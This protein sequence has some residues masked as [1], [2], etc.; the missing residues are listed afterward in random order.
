MEGIKFSEDE[1]AKIVGS[2]DFSKLQG[3]LPALAVDENGRVLMLA[4]M[5]REAV[6]RTLK[7][8]MMHYWSR[9]RKRLWMKGEESGHHQYVLGAY[10]DCDDDSLLFRVHQVGPACHT[11][12]KTCFFKILREFSGGPEVLG[13]LEEVIRDRMQNPVEGSHTS[14][15]IRKGIKQAAKK[16]GEEA[17]EVAVAALAEDTERTVYEAADLLYH[18]E[19]LL[20][21]K[22]TGIGEVY[23][24]LARRRKGAV[25]EGKQKN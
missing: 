14:D 5:N 7:T 12:E 8:G 13:D 16:V 9:S 21:M 17:T 15:V 19:I 23:G 3:I 24:E 11:G 25:Q 18:L 6:E 20:Q 1:T 4:F 10:S 22:G 2:L